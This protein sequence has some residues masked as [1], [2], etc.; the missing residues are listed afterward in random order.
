M[1][2]SR[3]KKRISLIL[4]V[5]MLFSI[6]S[7]S[8]GY[9]ADEVED[10]LN[11]TITEIE[12][13]FEEVPEQIA[14]EVL[15]EL[16]EQVASEA[17]EESMEQVIDEEVSSTYKLYNLRGFIQE[18]R[19][20][21]LGEYSNEEM[22]LEDGV[23]VGNTYKFEIT[24]SLPS[25]LLKDEQNYELFYQLPD[26]L[27]IDSK[28]YEAAFYTSNSAITGLYTIDAYGL[29]SVW[30]EDIR[31]NYESYVV[32][33]LEIEAIVSEDKGS[34]YLNFGYGF[35]V[36]INQREDVE[37]DTSVEEVIELL[38]YLFAALA[39]ID[40]SDLANF[41]TSATMWDANGNQITDGGNAILGNTYTFVMT[42]SEQPTIEG[43][44][45][46][47]AN[48][49]LTYQLPSALTVQTAVAATPIPLA[50]GAI[51]GYYTID[52]TGL[53]EV[54]FG[55]F[56]Q[57]GNPTAGINFIDVVA[58]ANFTL[59]IS[60][61]LNS[62]SL[63]F[64]DGSFI[65]INPVPPPT[66]LSVNKVSR[67]DSTSQRIYYT[68]T[69]T[70]LGGSIGDISLTDTPTVTLTGGTPL[71]I[72]NTYPSVISAPQY[73]LTRVG[74][75]INYLP[76]SS[77][78]ES[79]VSNPASVTTNFNFDM[80]G[81]TPLVLNEGDFLTV[82]YYIDI[83]ALIADN[84]GILAP[85][86]AQQYSF[87][88]NNNASVLSSAN[89]VVPVTDNTT[90]LVSRVLFMQKAGTHIRPAAGTTDPDQIKWTIVIG[91]GRSVLLNGGTIIDNLDAPLARLLMPAS[92]DISITVSDNTF[93]VPVTQ[94]TYAN[95]QPTFTLNTPNP[96]FTFIVPSS[97]DIFYDVNG[98]A[99]G[100]QWGDIYQITIVFTT[101]IPAAYLPGPITFH[102]T[103]DFN[104]QTATADVPI[105]PYGFSLIKSSFGICGRP[106]APLGPNGERYF[107]DYQIVLSIPEGYMNQP[108]YL[109]DT[110]GMMP[111]GSAV[112][113]PPEFQSVVLSSTE[114]LWPDQVWTQNTNP[115]TGG[116]NPEEFG[117][118]LI[119]NQWFMF[120]GSGTTG[121]G[122]SFWP[123]NDD[124]TLTIDYRIWIS[125]GANGTT[126]W[127]Q[128]LQQNP[129][130]YL[131]NVAY[132]F[133]SN[134]YPWE[135]PA[136]NAD[137]K[138]NVNDYW[139]I[140]KAGAQSA[141]NPS[142]FNYTVTLK[143]NYSYSPYTPGGSPTLF[144]DDLAPFF[145]DTFDPR[146]EFVPGSFYVFAGTGAYF[147][148]VADAGVTVGSGT[149]SVDFNSLQ[150]FAAVPPEGG[151]Q[152]G[153]TVY[154]N[155]YVTPA[156]LVVYY[157]LHLVDSTPGVGEP[158]LILNNT[159]RVTRDIAA[160]ACAFESTTSMHYNVNKLVKVMTPTSP[161]S[162]IMD[163]VITINPDGLTDFEP[164]GWTGPPLD[165]VF[166]VDTLENLMLFLE[167]VQFQTQTLVDG[168][169]DGNWVNVDPATVTFNQNTYWSI[170]PVSA[171]EVQFVIPNRQPVRILY[172][173]MVTLEAN[174]VGDVGNT[175]EIWGLVS[176]DGKPGYIVDGNEI[177]AGGGM[178]TLRIF[179]SDAESG[180][181]LQGAQFSLY[182]TI[183]P[184]YGQPFGTTTAQD[185][186]V[187]G[188]TQTFY[189]VASSTTDVNGLAE[190]SGY[191]V[192]NDTADLLFV[193]VE[194]AAPYGYILPSEP[195]NFTFF[196]I[197]NGM[198]ATFIS[199]AEALFGTINQISDFM[200][201]TNMPIEGTIIIQKTFAPVDVFTEDLFST[202]SF[203]VVGTDANQ[204]IIY[205]NTV[206]FT[207]FVNGVYQFTNL[208]AGTYVI[209]EMGGIVAGFYPPTP[210]GLLGA[211]TIPSST[212]QMTITVPIN[213][214]YV[215]IVPQTTPSLRVHK[216]FHGLMPDEI[217]QGFQ[218]VI[219]GPENTWT[220]GLDDVLAG[221]LLV[222]IPAGDYIIEERNANVAGFDLVATPTLPY[223]VT[224]T[225]Q[226]T[227]VTVII[228][229]IY[230]KVEQIVPPTRPRPSRP[231]VHPPVVPPTDLP[232]EPPTEPPIEHPPVYPPTEP[233]T[234]L[235]EEQPPITPTEPPTTTPATGD[236][237]VTSPQTGDHRQ[238]APFIALLIVGMICMVG[239][240]VYGYRR[241]RSVIR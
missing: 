166:A 20:F 196:T 195:D 147:A 217:P 57:N 120:W 149:F 75:G 113:I 241:R 60:A 239:A 5:A 69:M 192:I 13:S 46:Y 199:D 43:Q 79:W 156:Q 56:D 106:D 173:A 169:W 87:N 97:G 139:P 212:G 48:G 205:R 55:N 44:F 98:Q 70:A 10:E 209:Y 141:G 3:I 94:T 126:N 105:V 188:S 78:T 37:E 190:F 119:T 240:F 152:T 96:G 140:F 229:N 72:L 47:N 220:F 25:Y 238:M 74:Q 8:Y 73:G 117:I 227:E 170:N 16:P 54:W 23:F 208:P 135:A 33:A 22:N 14:D 134:R 181:P 111:A 204:N 64:G 228:N 235:P 154:T 122:N 133:N 99:T 24:F 148:P 76:L 127:L 138:M 176:G 90:D 131:Q 178:T 28:V 129:V 223:T 86:T 136:P 102:N 162:N 130:N 143:G 222:D 11:N 30:F 174:T 67:Y 39:D 91:D 61:Q 237:N 115:A 101:D 142:I 124:A 41:I 83:Q 179:K 77:V 221:I 12:V 197:K 218:I 82:A 132:L 104:G 59:Q 112:I 29:V 214:V 85:N 234:D 215:P 224:I 168:V 15:E 31:D 121:I 231:P 210:E 4:A 226:D 19:I 164:V 95:W 89:P 88:I 125:E 116:L 66:M 40:Q 92:T 108:F 93:P 118:Q 128:I 202:L 200:N 100:A 160:T 150:Q 145:T 157:Q 225:A 26:Q 58:N 6:V 203:K 151:W 32:F 177:V 17:L 21:D 216:V 198:D 207:D 18:I 50:N 171:D 146:M 165:S 180:V 103:V 161:G 9:A 182:A 187:N 186:T 68:I 65:T 232:E 51:V 163:I 49:R 80:D 62:S 38:E 34:G 175:I 63:D 27:L 172:E 211:V 42:F 1:F 7:F 236:S 35:E 153:G 84:A 137:V 193:L 230:T 110:L 233:T 184:S 2:I 189:L 158:P 183:L 36:Y 114:G 191:S 52:T 201:I 219:T 45:I 167:S 107:I 213:N 144:K 206:F 159:A 71:N 81:T 155:W 185:I 53:V 123:I 194:T 109:F